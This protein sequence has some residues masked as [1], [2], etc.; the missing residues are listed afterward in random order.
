[1]RRE[2]VS[3]SDKIRAVVKAIPAGETL[4]YAEVAKRA[5]NAKAARL[6]ARI[7][8]QNYDKAIPCHRVIYADGRIGNYNRG[9]EAA[10]TALLL[11]EGWQ[12]RKTGKNLVHH[13]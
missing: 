6:V 12:G 8:S 3:L 11:A 9:G 10:K 5:G 1:M 4:S 13:T 7:M 2:N